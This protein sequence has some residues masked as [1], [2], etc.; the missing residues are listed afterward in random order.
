MNIFP[1]VEPNFLQKWNKLLLTFFVPT[2]KQW[3]HLMN[4]RLFYFCLRKNDNIQKKPLNINVYSL[5]SQDSS[6]LLDHP[7]CLQVQSNALLQQFW[8]TWH[9]LASGLLSQS[10][11]QTLLSLQ[12]LPSEINNGNYY[13]DWSEWK[14]K[15]TAV[16]VLWVTVN[17]FWVWHLYSN[18]ALY[19]NHIRSAHSSAVERVFPCGFS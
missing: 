9:A 19:C 4:T 18:S 5:T 13:R 10:L 15:Q 17:A 6:W 11:F 3:I 7:F 1:G 12:R 14:N 16:S 2:C 8:P